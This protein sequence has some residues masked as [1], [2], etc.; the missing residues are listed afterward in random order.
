VES[1]QEKGLVR[2][3]AVFPGSHAGEPGPG[4]EAGEGTGEGIGGEGEGKGGSWGEEKAREGEGREV[5]S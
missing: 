1:H 3:P 5:L 4:L 2:F